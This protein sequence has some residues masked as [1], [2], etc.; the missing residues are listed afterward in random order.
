MKMKNIC[1][2]AL[3]MFVA[4]NIV[5]LI[6]KGLRPGIPAVTADDRSDRLIVYYFHRKARCP[7]CRNIEVYSHEAVATSFP[8]EVGDSRI[9]WKVVDFEEPENQCFVED[10]ELLAPSVVLV[11]M[12]GGVRKRW[13]SLP[14]VWELVGDKPAFIAFVQK[15]VQAFLNTK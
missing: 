1:T 14:E 4:V 11:E 8:A 15:E 2:G 13:K 6:V 9:E 7:P 10:F 5:V 12:R 3:L